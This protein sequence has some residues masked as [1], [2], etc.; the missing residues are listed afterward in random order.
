MVYNPIQSRKVPDENRLERF[1]GKIIQSPKGI[2]IR[3]QSF[4]EEP[5]AEHAPRRHHNKDMVRNYT[6]SEPFRAFFVD[7]QDSQ[8]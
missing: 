8:P 3:C 1:R 7:R 6:K 2:I 5:V 4:L